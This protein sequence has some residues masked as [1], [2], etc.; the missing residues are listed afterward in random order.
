M[1]KITVNDLN[2]GYHLVFTDNEELFLIRVILDFQNRK[3]GDVQKCLCIPYDAFNINLSGD[4]KMQ[5]LESYSD[6]EFTKLEELDYKPIKCKYP[7][8]FI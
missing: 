4:M 8:C 3:M 7:E 2:L 5:L 1:S 6:E